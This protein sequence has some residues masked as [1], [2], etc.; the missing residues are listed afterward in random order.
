MKTLTQHIVQDNGTEY[1]ITHIYAESGYFVEKSKKKADRSPVG[2][3]IQLGTNDSADNYVEVP[4]ENE[5]HI[6]PDSLPPLYV[7]VVTEEEIEAEIK[8][9]ELEYPEG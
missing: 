5:V 2:W 3:H 8:A 9:A 1:D 7:H 4:D 6:I